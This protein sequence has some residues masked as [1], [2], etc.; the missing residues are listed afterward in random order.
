MQGNAHRCRIQSCTW[1]SAGLLAHLT[2]IKVLAL[3]F[4]SGFAPCLHN[5]LSVALWN[6]GRH[7]ASFFIFETFSVLN[8]AQKSSKRRFGTRRWGISAFVQHGASARFRAQT[9]IDM[10]LFFDASC[11][12]CASNRVWRCSLGKLCG[13][14]RL[15]MFAKTSV[16]F[17]CLLIFAELSHEKDSIEYRV[18]FV[19]CDRIR[20]GC[21]SFLL[22]ASRR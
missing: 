3:K 2:T 12:S 17:P 22:L 15:S 10:Y 9:S 16:A 5:S 1:S 18:L 14:C 13:L 8:R 21:R 20:P 7:P 11:I 6:L 4:W 19:N